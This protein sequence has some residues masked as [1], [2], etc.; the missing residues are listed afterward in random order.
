ML[1]KI[2]TGELIVIILVALFIVGPER[3]PKLA[4]SV[5][6]T[7]ASFKRY[8]GDITKEL[9]ESD[10][11]LK[12]VSDDLKSVKKDLTESM[13][14]TGNALEKSITADGKET[15]PDII[16]AKAEK[17]VAEK[18]DEA[19]RAEGDMLEPTV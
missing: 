10:V 11:D 1:S 13:K 4:R 17:S 18:P 14:I 19:A 5:G 7:V 2:G 6:K 8:M 16:K 3:L 9:R 15:K 12:S